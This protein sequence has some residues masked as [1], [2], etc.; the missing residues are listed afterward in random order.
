MLEESAIFLDVKINF[1]KPFIASAARLATTTSA[2][3]LKPLEAAIA[4]SGSA[5]RNLG[6][7]VVLKN[8]IAAYWRH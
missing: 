2:G 1:G 4:G 8:W 7:M 3:P 5:S 6:A